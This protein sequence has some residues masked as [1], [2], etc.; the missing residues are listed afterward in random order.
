MVTKNQIIEAINKTLSKEEREYFFAYETVEQVAEEL[1]NK[2]Y[3]YLESGGSDNL[4]LFWDYCNNELIALEG[5]YEGDA[6]AD[7]PERIEWVY[8]QNFYALLELYQNKLNCLSREAIEFLRNALAN[9][10]E[11]KNF[12]REWI[13]NTVDE[14]LDDVLDIIFSRRRPSIPEDKE[15]FEEIV[16][17]FAEE[18][19][20]YITWTID[21]NEL[22]PFEV[23]ADD[24]LEVDGETICEAVRDRLPREIEEER[25]REA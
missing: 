21:E 11:A 3:H 24:V 4:Y 12:T 17:D 25:K 8:R 9:Y 23:D 2:G 10:N 19:A 1:L 20:D 14:E 18:V 7:S 5:T 6:H 15:E 16:E 22:F 13:R